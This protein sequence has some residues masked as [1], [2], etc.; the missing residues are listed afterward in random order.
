[1][2]DIKPI[3]LIFMVVCGIVA[4]LMGVAR[5]APLIAA[6]RAQD[7][8]T[9]TDTPAPSPTPTDAATPIL[10]PTIAVT[11]SPTPFPSAQLLYLPYVMANHNTAPVI[12]SAPAG[13]IVSEDTAITLT[14]VISDVQSDPSTLLLSAT[15]LTPTLI[16]AIAIRGTDDI[17]SVMITPT[18]NSTGDVPISITV[19]DGQLQ[20]QHLFVLTL[21]PVNDVPVI[22]GLRDIGVR[23]D[24]TRTIVF[25]V[26][27]VESASAGL[28]VT[29]DSA[30]PMLLPLGNM[31]LAGQGVTRSL[32][33][34]PAAGLTG[35]GIISIAVS[36]G[37]S[38]SIIPFTLTVSLDICPEVSTNSF[39]SVAIQPFNG[40]VYYKDN[41]LTDENVDFRLMLL[42]YTVTN[43]LKDLVD[44]GGDVDPLAPRIYGVFH[45][46][47]TVVITQTY[48]RFD[49]NWNENAPPPYGNRGGI[50]GEW[51]VSIIDLSTNLGEN[52][53]IPERPGGLFQTGIWE[54][55]YKAL[56]LYA[57][58]NDLL[59]TYTR[60]DRVDHG[61][62]LYLSNFCVDVNLVKVYRDQLVQ[63]KRSTGWL[64]ALRNADVV[65][66]ARNHPLT[67]AIRD[68][69]PFL[70][71]R[72]RKDW[73]Q[74][75]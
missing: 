27:D 45:P 20:N 46:T 33:I 62:A 7:T 61:Y 19:S 18:L 11:P 28:T 38:S 55:D 69:G 9:V 50:N 24:L 65:G 31:A 66:T 49:W 16:D 15:P 17:R 22:S 53:Y 1:M 44:Y 52:I 25:S 35:M 58:E 36:D 4:G 13:V 51:P 72:A 14:V 21:L 71:P 68:S 43:Q 59:I 40:G 63:G 56:V 73:W 75:Y 32:A 12:L 6:Y 30:N 39:I 54:G 57:S 5:P 37:E 29:F 2:R 42:G 41:R 23:P 26:T 34:T 10:N 8:S 74:G 48:Q 70:D 64:P 47:R 67:V 60:N 3:S